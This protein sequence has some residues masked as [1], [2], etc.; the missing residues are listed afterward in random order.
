VR[1]VGRERERER[2]FG[3]RAADGQDPQG[4]GGGGLTAART[5]RLGDGGGGWATRRARHGGELGRVPGGPRGRGARGPVGL[6]GGGGRAERREGDF[7][8]SNFFLFSYYLF[9]L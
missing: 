8:F 3:G 1:G 4:E 7:P 6:R 2:G 9:Y 5:T